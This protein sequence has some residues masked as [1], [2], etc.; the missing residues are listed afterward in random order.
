MLGTSW[1]GWYSYTYVVN[2]SG[3]VIIVDTGEGDAGRKG[4]TAAAGDFDLDTGH[5]ELDA[6]VL[7]ALMGDFG[8]VEGD[9]FGAEEIT[10]YERISNR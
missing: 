1:D 9:E 6:P 10:R 2:E 5:V 8:F 3:V 7:V 4:Y